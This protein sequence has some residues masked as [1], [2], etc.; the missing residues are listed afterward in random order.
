MASRQ[1]RFSV[2]R[3]HDARCLDDGVRTV[4]DLES[5]ILRRI[6]RNDRHDRNARR[7]LER[8]FG[9]HRAWL[10]LANDSG[11]R[12]A[13]AQFHGESPWP[14]SSEGESID[15]YAGIEEFDR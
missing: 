1:A 6:E 11:Q 5:Q 7:D 8:D 9:I 15:A 4:S 12:I 13:R 2:D 3:H 14:D 10:N